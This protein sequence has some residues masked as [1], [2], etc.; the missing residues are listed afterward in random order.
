MV[1]IPANAIKRLSVYYRFLQDELKA[2]EVTISSSQL[3]DLTG[4]TS[5]QIR[6]DLAYFGQFGRRGAGYP[7]AALA[8]E[9]EKI[10]G[11]DRPKNVAIIGAGNLG[12]AL[13]A[14]KGFAEQGFHLVAIFDNTAVKIGRKISGIDCYF[15]GRLEPIIKKN[16]I[17]LAIL[18]VPARAAQAVAEKLARAGIKG[19]LNF[20]PTNLTVPDDVKVINVDLTME[21][22]SLSYFLKERTF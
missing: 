17:S 12:R 19:I 21:L 7:I 14:Y 20:A 6:R 13:A 11:L 5:D 16:K 18:T 3:A 15:W 8:L 22:E 9:I 4:M 10:L 1:K 2:G